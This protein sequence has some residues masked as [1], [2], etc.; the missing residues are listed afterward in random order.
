MIAINEKRNIFRDVR[1]LIKMLFFMMDSSLN[2]GL[3]VKLIN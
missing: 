2:Q 3:G 1:P